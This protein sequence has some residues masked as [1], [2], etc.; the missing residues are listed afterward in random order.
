M[1]NPDLLNSLACLVRRHELNSHILHSLPNPTKPV[2]A[3]R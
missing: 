3:R 1:M 2:K